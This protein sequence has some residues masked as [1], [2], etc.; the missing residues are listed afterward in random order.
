VSAAAS[1]D[2]TII[3]AVRS[4]LPDVRAFWVFGSHAQGTAQ[5]TSDL[6]LA[7]LFD[8]RADVVAL[9]EAAQDL[10]CRLD[11]DVDLVD[12]LAA[13]TVLQFQ[14]VT[15]GRRLFARDPLEADLYEVFIL[16][17]MTR[18]REARAALVEDIQQRGRVHGR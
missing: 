9:W 17:E 1:S 8:G 11:M 2:A 6:D 16:S 14:I 4:V 13:S 12:L 18:L 5:P 3:E 15:G 10:A 7:V